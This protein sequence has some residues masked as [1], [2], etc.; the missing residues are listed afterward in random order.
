MRIQKAIK[1]RKHLSA[2]VIAQIRFYVKRLAIQND[3][4]MAF[5]INTLLARSL[6]INID[7]AYD[8]HV[9]PS[10]KRT[11]KVANYRRVS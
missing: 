10:K 1:N 2:G 7:E 5:V 6:R 8:E 4:S 9:R 3:C 11:G